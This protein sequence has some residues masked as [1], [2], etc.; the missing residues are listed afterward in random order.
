VVKR[1]SHNNHIFIILSNHQEQSSYYAIIHYYYINLT[2]SS[3]HLL[4]S[5]WSA[6]S[7]MPSRGHIALWTSQFIA[8]QRR[9]SSHFQHRSLNITLS[10]FYYISRGD[11]A[12]YLLTLILFF[13][14]FSQI[15]NIMVVE[16][17]WHQRPQ[18]FGKDFSN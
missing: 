11:D 2:Q 13:N 3:S 16:S 18:W 9:S 1:K 15:L 14:F 5:M 12:S 8:L 6:T 4:L 10:T 7:Y 17:W